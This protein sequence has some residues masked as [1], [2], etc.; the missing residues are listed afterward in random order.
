MPSAPTY[1]V[2]AIG[3]AHSRWLPPTRIAPAMVH[4]AEAASR[5]LGLRSGERWCPGEDLNLHGVLTPLGP[6]PSA[7]ANSATWAR[8]E[9]P[10]T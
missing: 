1:P 6:E 10:E 9:G 7:S 4:P 2:G 3:W 5:I 8:N